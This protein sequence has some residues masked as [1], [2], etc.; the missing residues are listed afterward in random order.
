MNSIYE[1]I[2]AKDP[3]L[4]KKVAERQKTYKNVDDMI[5]RGVTMQKKYHVHKRFSKEMDYAIARLRRI[6]HD[7]RKIANH[8]GKSYREIERLVMKTD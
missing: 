3:V 5:A 8:T 6:K 4:A 7:I 1:E 2:L